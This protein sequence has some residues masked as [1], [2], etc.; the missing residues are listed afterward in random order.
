MAC[1]CKEPQSQAL[2]ELPSR[3]F[4]TLVEA[5]AELNRIYGR[6]DVD[7][8]YILQLAS[9]GKIAVHWLFNE[10]LDEFFIIPYIINQELINDKKWA[11]IQHDLLRFSGIKTT[12]MFFD[13]GTYRLEKFILNESVETDE[14]LIINVLP[15]IANKFILDEKLNQSVALYFIDLSESRARRSTIVKNRFFSK[16]NG[17]DSEETAELEETSFDDNFLIFETYD[18]ILSDA[19]FRYY[20]E[21]NFTVKKSDLY[22]L[23]YDIEL[24]KNGEFRNR[25]ELASFADKQREILN[26]RRNK[27][28]QKQERPT[29]QRKQVLAALRH[30]ADLN[31]GRPHSDAEVLLAHAITEGLEMP[32]NLKTVAKHMYPD[33]NIDD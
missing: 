25:E 7:E 1:T 4:Y 10:L 6:T 12:P 26:Q 30:M 31:S 11:E 19:Q 5:A 22:V 28:G 15:L 29:N 24:I 21:K 18:E 20:H 8:N 13:I 14:L 17:N 33:Q 16:I 27:T 32:A 23:G 3:Q 2:A 9:M